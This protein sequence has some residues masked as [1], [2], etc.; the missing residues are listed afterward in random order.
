MYLM[1][2]LDNTGTRVYTM[3]KVIL[4]LLNSSCNGTNMLSASLTNIPD[5]GS[6]LIRIH[7]SNEIN[8]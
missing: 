2:Y 3:A 6:V 1:Y 4:F 8:I 5:S 7:P